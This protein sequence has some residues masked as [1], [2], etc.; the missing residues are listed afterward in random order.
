[1][2]RQ[3]LTEVIDF[4]EAGG[5]RLKPVKLRP[6]SAIEVEPH[7]TVTLSGMINSVEGSINIFPRTIQNLNIETSISENRVGITIKNNSKSKYRIDE[8][9]VLAELHTSKD[10]FVQALVGPSCT[11]KVEIR[12]IKVN[13]LIDS[14]SQVTIIAKSLV[15]QLGLEIRPIDFK[16]QVLGAGDQAVKYHGYTEVTMTTP[17]R[18]IGTAEPVTVFALVCP[19]NANSDR[20]P[21]IIG[22][23]ILKKVMD[24]FTVNRNF[25][26]LDLP[27]ETVHMFQT[28]TVNCCS[29]TLGDMVVR[30]KKTTIPAGETVEVRLGC[31]KYI[32]PNLFSSVMIH[33]TED[34]QDFLQIAACKVTVGSDLANL[35][36]TVRNVSDS[37]VHLSR[38]QCI[39][40]VYEIREECDVKG[41]IDHIQSQISQPKSVFAHSHS[42]T[43]PCDKSKVSHNEMNQKFKFGPDIPEMARMSFLNK[44]QGYTDVFIQ[45]EFDV[46]FVETEEVDVQL[47][48][49]PPIYHRPRPL[50]KDE[51]EEVKSHLQGLLDAKIIAPSASDFSSPIV[52]VR[53]KNGKIRMCV[54]YR[55]INSRILKD[56]YCIPKI[57]D[58]FSTLSGAQ[59]FTSMDLSK[60]Y[61]QLP[62]SKNAQRISAFTTPVGNFTW[63]RMPMGLKNSGSQF[64]RLIEKVFHDMNLIE[65]IVFLDDILVHG[66]TLEELESRTFAAL[67]RL[68]AYGLKLDPE[69]CVFGAR[70]VKHL[71]FV[72]SSEGIKPDPD[73]IKALIEYPVPKTVREVKAF[74][75]FC[76]FYR[77]MVPN[78]AI[79]AKP[80]Y[81]VTEGYIP[82]KGRR[83]RKP[84]TEK[85]ILN[86]TSDISHRW[87]ELEQNAFEKLIGALTQEPVIGVADKDLPFELR[88]DSSGYGIGSILIQEQQGETKVISYASRTLNKTEANYPAHKREFLAMKWSLDKFRDYVLGS[89]VVVYTDSN[90]LCYVLKSAQ[91]DATSHR[92]LASISM[93]DL[94]IR[95]KKGA[96]HLDADFL[97]R[98]P[99]KELEEDTEFL[100]TKKKIDFLV[101]KFR[102]VGE[103]E[104]VDSQAI[105]AICQ[106]CGVVRCDRMIPKETKSLSWD[107]PPIHPAIDQMIKDPEKIPEDILEPNELHPENEINW[108]RAQ[109]DDL[110]IRNVIES[111]KRGKKIQNDDDDPYFAEYRVFSREFDRLVIQ[112]G[113]LY[114]QTKD[115]HDND[116]RQ[117]VVPRAFRKQAMTGIHDDLCHTHF[118]DSMRQA[119]LRFFWPFMATDIKKKI[120]RCM[121][122]KKSKAKAEKAEMHSVIASYPLE[123]LSIDFLTIELKRVKQNILVVQD[124]FTKF[125]CAFLTKDQKT[126]TV[127]KTLWEQ[128]FLTYGFPARILSDNAKDFESDLI[129]EICAISG[130]KKC[131]TT[132]YHPSGNPVERWNRTLIGMLRTLEDDKKRD[133]RKH[134]KS[135]VHAYNACVSEATGYSPYYLFFGRHP[136]LPIDVAFGIN[137][138]PTRQSSK[139]YVRELKNSLQRASRN[140]SE[141]ITKKSEKNKARYDASAHAGELEPG[142]RV[143]VKKLGP[144]IDSKVSDRWEKEVYVV[145]KRP[146]LDIPVYVVKTESGNSTERTLHRNVLL[147][148]GMLGSEHLTTDTSRTQNETTVQKTGQ[149]EIKV[150]K[151]E[152]VP[153]PLDTVKN[154]TDSEAT[155]QLDFVVELSRDDVTNR[156]VLDPGAPVFIPKQISDK[157]TDQIDSKSSESVELVKNDRL[158]LT[159]EQESTGHSDTTEQKGA[160]G[161][162]GAD[163]SEDSEQVNDS[164]QKDDSEHETEDSDSHSPRKNQSHSPESDSNKSFLRRSARQ[165]KPVQKFTLGMQQSDKEQ[166]QSERQFGLQS[167]LDA[168]ELAISKS[169]ADLNPNALY[170]LSWCLYKSG[171]RLQKMYEHLWSLN[172][173]GKRDP[174]EKVQFL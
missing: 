78:F 20:M 125:S 59:Y 120:D 163:E 119:R 168:V 140:A 52:I 158:M 171:H 36:V 96:N 117:L 9:V 104:V 4:L 148:I 138:N 164:D 14:G 144:R 51:L 99:N 65:L 34:V 73:K 3:T 107:S 37:D 55:K 23:N 151:T 56:N 6:G 50:S 33:E 165:R 72:I 39:G 61:Y 2:E 13:A 115:S 92:W 128:F 21:I 121:R 130:I 67:D 133:W 105:S 116:I 48:P 38:N 143:L 80:L 134:L 90:P 131:R 98:I 169:A 150:P 109:M 103:V 66:K 111:V 135:V 5:N 86:L 53:K 82:S 114:R 137:L 127:A 112:D 25:L 79:I 156:A 126:K 157:Q 71:G 123:L 106:S 76:G 81:A 1:M 95:Y 49:G 43:V 7:Q 101:Q 97:S 47:E 100:R 172:H 87:G 132:I 15:D 63:L 122:C 8:N 83:G 58:L 113:V 141:Q 160:D 19:D 22:T 17:G 42:N 152:K 89:K 41:L 26:N 75:G 57:E 108:K 28:M 159:D 173:V 74:L 62:L 161:D 12:N 32:P 31:T 118:D 60:A 142:D 11:A 68:R 46:G 155:E 10:I 167:A 77:R 124:V 102:N 174:G 139:Q 16:F 27:M 45:D 166:F 85:E 40:A 153:Q 110:V 84:R 154:K 35:K 170:Q 162:P 93:F 18:E 147:P 30:Q 29:D 136:R 149:S 54:D 24:S 88:C 69:K 44:L 64:Q 146:N 91:L 94:E 129:K 70:E 145:V